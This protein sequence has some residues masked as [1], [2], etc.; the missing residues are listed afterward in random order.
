MNSTLEFLG[1]DIEN[2]MMSRFI[3]MMKMELEPDQLF[4]RVE[5]GQDF[6]D[7]GGKNCAVVMTKR[8]ISKMREKSVF[9]K[10]CF[11]ELRQCYDTVEEYMGEL[12]HNEVQVEG[13]VVS[14][15]DVKFP[16]EWILEIFLKLQR[17]N[18]ELKQGIDRLLKHFPVDQPLAREVSDS[19]LDNA[20]RKDVNTRIS[21]LEDEINDLRKKSSHKPLHH[22]AS[23]L[24]LRGPKTEDQIISLIDWES[25]L[26]AIQPK[27]DAKGKP[28][29]NVVVKSG[30][31]AR[32]ILALDG[33]TFDGI[34]GRCEHSKV[35]KSLIC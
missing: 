4:E 24:Y 8:C 10:I 2:E 34:R 3:F 28:C 17:D 15:S 31:A 12:A 18:K 20:F 21:S 33:Q 23:C 22:G 29:F 7:S 19:G 6:S 35:N 14:K 13:E 9:I 5:I 16:L 30:F 11:Q 27:H 26:L 1:L 32:A 25:N